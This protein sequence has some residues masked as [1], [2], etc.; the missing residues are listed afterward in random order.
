MPPTTGPGSTHEPEVVPLAER[1]SSAAVAGRVR[2]AHAQ[3]G[4]IEDAE[5]LGADLAAL[6]AETSEEDGG[7]RQ[8]RRRLERRR[9]AL[10]ARELRLLRLDEAV[11]REVLVRKGSLDGIMS[12]AGTTRCDELRWIAR[13]TGIARPRRLN[14]SPPPFRSST[15]TT[16]RRSSW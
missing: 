5:R 10:A 16:S 6:E 7:G 15:P 1:T 3:R 2:E 4:L 11:V 14:A 9:D 12:V 13:A 8:R